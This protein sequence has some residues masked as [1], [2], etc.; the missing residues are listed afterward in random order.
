MRLA[1]TEVADVI[2]VVRERVR[3]FDDGDYNDDDDDEEG[4][5]GKN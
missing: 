4:N 5:G 3:C 1:R 2:V